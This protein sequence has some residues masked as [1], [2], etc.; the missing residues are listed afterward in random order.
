M[1]VFLQEVEIPIITYRKEGGWM[2]F[3]LQVHSK[4]EADTRLNAVKEFSPFNE[5]SIGSRF[6]DFKE[7]TGT[8]VCIYNLDRWGSNY[9]LQWDP[10]ATEAGH[11]F[12]C[13]I[14]IRSRRVRSRPSQM[15][16]EV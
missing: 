15:T 10:K 4:E 16:K 12:K 3:D 14:T 13:D 6:S 1:F 9:S 7:N 2:E 8:T 11:R 5:Y